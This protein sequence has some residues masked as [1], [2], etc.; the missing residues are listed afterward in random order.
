MVSCRS[1]TLS[2]HRKGKKITA[3]NSQLQSS[4]KDLQLK[5]V[6]GKITA[7]NDQL[8]SI[9]KDLQL[10]VLKEFFFDDALKLCTRNKVSHVAELVA[11]IDDAVA[12]AAAFRFAIGNRNCKER[13]N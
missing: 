10:K 1:L 2:L 9:P 3:N 4:P 7:N 8:Q 5:V 6:K 13:E 12:I 11:V